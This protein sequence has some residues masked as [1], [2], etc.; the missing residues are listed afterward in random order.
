MMAI[1]KALVLL[2][3]GVA[4][5][6]GIWVFSPWL[7]GKDEPWDA[8]Q[9]IWLLSWLVVAVLGGMTSHIRGICLPLGYALGQMLVTIQSVFL[10]PFGALGW[11][12]IGSYAAVAVVITLALV[13]VTALLKYLWRMRRTKAG[14]A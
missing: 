8:D 11:I 1:R 7:T 4:L 12:F 9:P 5:G 14:D 2:A 6:V 3:L 10:G 13:G